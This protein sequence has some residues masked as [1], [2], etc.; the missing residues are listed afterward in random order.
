M[1]LVIIFLPFIKLITPVLSPN[2]PFSD[3]K[4]MKLPLF[5]FAGKYI[6][7]GSACLLDYYRTYQYDD[8]EERRIYSND[9]QCSMTLPAIIGYTIALFII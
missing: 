7:L 2:D 5:K 4:Y 1:F 3:P 8:D 9:G 6:S